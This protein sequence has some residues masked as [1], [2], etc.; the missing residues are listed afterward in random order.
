[1]ELRVNMQNDAFPSLAKMSRRSDDHYLFLL[2]LLHTKLQFIPDFIHLLI[3]SF[4][5]L[6]TLV[7]VL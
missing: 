7:S 3:Y 4:F 1:M 2:L 5:L 6:R